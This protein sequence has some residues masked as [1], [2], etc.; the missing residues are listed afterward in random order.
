M[1]TTAAVNHWEQINSVLERFNLNKV[2][3]MMIATDWTWG[4]PFMNG[5]F[6]IPTVDAMR[7]QCTQLMLESYRRE[8]VVSAGGFE[9]V[10]IPAKQ[11]VALRFIAAVCY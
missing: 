11:I 10:W 2:R 9:A 8:T 5:E 7:S 4:G 6:D 1:T 3:K